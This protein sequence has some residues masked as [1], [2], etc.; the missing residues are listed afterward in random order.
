MFKLKKEKKSKIGVFG[1]TFNPPH[2]GHLL[3][4]KKVIKK[5]GFKKLL[6][7]VTGKPA[8]KTKDLAPIKDR[9]EMTKILAQYHPKFEVSKIEIERAK[10]GKKSYTIETIGELK[11]RYKNEEI[12][13]I[14]GEDSLN[15]ILEG[16]W[17]GGLKIF[18]EAKFVVIE[19]PGYKK[20]IPKK[21]KEKIEIIKLNIP[22]SSTEIREK[23]RKKEDVSKM[24]P[25]K[26]LKYI[27]KKKLYEKNDAKKF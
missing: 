1:G 9:L 15:E 22:I 25:I 19:R 14:I 3:I 10:K 16:K 17:K 23:I 7:M 13:W 11:K 21:I 27:K 8:L 26:I 2:L 6:L 5:F 20:K 4:A 18:D 12:Y 24:V